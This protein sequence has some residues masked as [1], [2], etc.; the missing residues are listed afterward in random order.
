ML[1]SFV[2]Y[3]LSLGPVGV[4]VWIAY[5]VLM[6]I[7]IVAVG[8]AF[9]DRK[10]NESWLPVWGSLLMLGMGAIS[11]V[12]WWHF[13]PVSMG[14]ILLGWLICIW[15]VMDGPSWFGEV[16]DYGLRLWISIPFIA[17]AI[18]FELLLRFG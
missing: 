10:L 13:N 8:I 14:I 6:L 5:G 2:S 3:L 9:R 12:G 18:V 11:G 1:A 4:I 16:D 7:N 17:S 15:G